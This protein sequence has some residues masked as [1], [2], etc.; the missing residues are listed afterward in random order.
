MKHRIF[1]AINLPEKIKERIERE[2][3]KISLN[4]PSLAKIKWVRR[5][6]L[7]ITVVF[8]GYVGDDEIYK[9]IEISKKIARKYSPFSISLERIIAEPPGK[10]PRMFWVEGAKSEELARLQTELEN[11]II[12]KN[13]TGRKIKP[14]RPHITLARF[15]PQYL[16]NLAKM[17][18]EFKATIFVE[19][20]EIM[21]SN[22][23]KDGPEYFVLENIKL[24]K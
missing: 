8:I 13:F 18:K 4:F 2:R 23:K 24:G 10:I 20:I 7:H 5:E 14:Y 11:S 22:L 21:E 1:V 15:K 16:E 17:N 3:E 19:T 12:N 9:I 6:N